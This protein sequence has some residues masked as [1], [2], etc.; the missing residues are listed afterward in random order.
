MRAGG[1]FRVCKRLISR[2]LL[3]GFKVLCV[4][5]GQRP[6]TNPKAAQ[7]LHNHILKA[8]NR[9]AHL[10]QISPKP[11]QTDPKSPLNPPNWRAASPA[12]P[13]LLGLGLPV[14]FDLVAVQSCSWGL[15]RLIHEGGGVI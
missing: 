1:S 3:G 5:L 7:K 9:P 6:T 15:L 14:G 11:T 12:S 8:K 4:G 2:M 10:A 13:A